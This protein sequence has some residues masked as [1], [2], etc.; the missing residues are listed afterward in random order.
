MIDKSIPHSPISMFKTDTKSYPEYALPDGYSFSFYQKGD[1]VAWARLERAL[2]QFETEALALEHFQKDFYDGQRLRPEERMLFVK[3]SDGEIVGTASLWDGEYF[4]RIEQRIHWVAVSDRCAGQGIAK[5]M[6]TRL[7]QLYNTLGYEGYLYL[8]TGTVN[9][10]AIAIYRK[11]G[12]IE[13]R[14]EISPFT[15]LPDPDFAAM[16]RTGLATLVGKIGEN[17][18]WN[19]RN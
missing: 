11:F 5:A 10:P 12:F 19:E 2:G 13:Y 15:N 17:P 18:L 6:L 8:W 3:D 9:Y 7:L 16:N 14:G 4:G 1:E